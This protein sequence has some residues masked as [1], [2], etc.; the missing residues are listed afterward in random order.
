SAEPLRKLA[1]DP[2]REIGLAAIWS[3]ANMGDA[4]SLELVLRS[5][6]AAGFE[7][8]K[9]TQACLLLAENLLAPGN[10]KPAVRIYTQIRDKRPEPAEAYLREAASRGLQRVR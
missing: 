9:A 10:T 7:R 3:L 4:G 8:I 6:D 1:A 2:D 5:A